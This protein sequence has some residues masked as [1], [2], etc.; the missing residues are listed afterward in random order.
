M[1]EC[2]WIQFD[3]QADEFL[4][5][6]SQCDTVCLK[7][8]LQNYI[9]NSLSKDNLLSVIN[10]TN[11]TVLLV[12]F[13]IKIKSVTRI[14]DENYCIL[15]TNIVQSQFRRQNVP[16]LGLLYWDRSN[17]QNMIQ[18][19]NV[20]LLW[21]DKMCLF[22]FGHCNITLIMATATVITTI[23]T[24]KT[25]TKCSNLVNCMIQ[26]LFLWYFLCTQHN[27][28]SWPV[29]QSMSPLLG[30]WFD[31]CVCVC[32]CAFAALSQLNLRTSA[33]CSDLHSSRGYKNGR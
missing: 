32:V 1:F 6:M 12:V 22:S 21:C 28:A 29:I 26:F 10:L 20:L 31:M 25:F 23:T 8:S 18:I 9:I 14:S 30:L 17:Y 13:F 16:I 15:D 2:C 11:H 24:K 3:K 5:N 4:Q 19:F 27:S 7:V 33:A